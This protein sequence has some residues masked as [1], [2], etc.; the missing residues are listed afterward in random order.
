M[1]DQWLGLSLQQYYYLYLQVTAAPDELNEFL[2]P[3]MRE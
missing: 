2:N 3:T 1:T